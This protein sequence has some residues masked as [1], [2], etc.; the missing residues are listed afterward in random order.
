MDFLPINPSVG[1]KYK[2]SNSVSYYYEWNGF[3]WE[4]Q[5]ESSGGST[6]KNAQKVVKEIINETPAGDINSVNNIFELISLPEENSETLYLNGLLQKRGLDYDYTIN[7]ST[8]TFNI[9]PLDESI[10]LCSYSTIDQLYNKNEEPSGSID[11]SNS[12]FTL[13]KRRIPCN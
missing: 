4:T 5:L 1:Q 3:A 11:G 13:S 10:I 7:E 8:I 12:I 9:P 6:D 2:I